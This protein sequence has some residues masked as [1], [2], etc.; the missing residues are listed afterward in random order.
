MQSKLD[1][2][3]QVGYMKGTKKMAL[4][5]FG[6][7]Y[8]LTH[9]YRCENYSGNIDF[10]LYYKN[11]KTKLIDYFSK[12]YSVDVLVCT[13]D[14]IIMNEIKNLYNPIK[15]IIDNEHGRAFK[16]FK[17]IEFLILNCNQYNYNVIAIT[18]FDIYFIK[19][20][21]NIDFDK[22]NFISILEHN[23]YCDD[24]FYFFPIKYLN[25][26]YNIL[27]QKI[28]NTHHL[29]D[30]VVLHTLTDSLFANFNINLLCDERIRVPAL[31]FFKLRYFDSCSTLILN[32]SDYSNDILY[33][34]YN[35]A[36]SI[37]IR[38]DT[39]IE[40]TKNM[41]NK[42]PYSWFGYKIKIPGIYEISFEIL[43]SE[44]LSTPF[45][46]LHDPV[47]FYETPTIIANILTKV[48]VVIETN[49]F[50]DLLCFIF[51]DYDKS[52]SI[53]FNNI[54]I[55]P[56]LNFIFYGFC[57]EISHIKNIPINC[58]KYIMTP[59]QKYEDKIEH[60]TYREI[61]NIFKENVI[62]CNIWEYDKT[63]F[64]KKVIEDYPDIPTFNQ[65][66]Q[67]PYRIL[68]FFYHIKMSLKLINIDS[69]NDNSILI[70]SRIDNSIKNINYLLINKTLSKYDII[71]HDKSGEKGV[72]DHYFI[73]KK[74]S[75]DTFITLYDSYLK[76]CNDFYNNINKHELN[77]TRPEDILYY[78]FLINQKKIAFIPIIEHNFIHV[79]NKFCGHNGANTFLLK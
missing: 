75:I 58:N 23:I 33:N 17:L 61:I 52:I 79:C 54:Q 72:Y 10:R 78:H 35:N 59:K 43:S 27:Q 66:F 60:I 15:I 62:N 11:I 34:S 6:L 69:L 12:F 38:N 40:F 49:S 51:D 48:A 53:T 55:T 39:T 32:I 47:K 20:F 22:F 67:Q 28:I 14:N 31:S 45:L 57:R 4:L 30:P 2:V 37:T 42:T 19:N 5:L 18:R 41:Y 50:S 13:K 68:S 56:V 29:D 76:Y 73:F 77:S 21:A 3:T 46:K 7:S 24:N 8:E 65:Y 63:I 36:T 26:F 74:N 16:L 44:N 64:S 1:L 9:K 25:K 71:V 70:I